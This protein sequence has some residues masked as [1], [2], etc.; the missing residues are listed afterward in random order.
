MRRYFP[1]ADRCAEVLLAAALLALAVPASAEDSA[2]DYLQQALENHEKVKAHY[3]YRYFSPERESFLMI[4]Q[5]VHPKHGVAATVVQPIDMAGM[6]TVD[7][8]KVMNVF[9]P[10]DQKVWVQASPRLTAFPIRQRMGLLNENYRVTFGEESSV[11]GREV[12]KIVISAKR[13]SVG[14]RLWYVD[15]KE[16][17]LLRSERVTEEGDV[18]PLLDVLLVFFNSSISKN[19]FKFDVDE[20]IEREKIPDPRPFK[21][22][23]DVSEELGFEPRIPRKLPYGFRTIKRQMIEVDDERSFVQIEVSD[24]M[25][26]ISIYQW[27][28]KVFEGANPS[29]IRSSAADIIGGVG[30]SAAGDAPP[31]VV[32]EILNQFVHASH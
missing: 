19:E 4:Q 32:K 11:A 27:S 28:Q 16:R 22:G 18:I 21:Y 9:S 31:S 23:K 13:S 8:G 29:G 30:F 5:F 6:R 25:G 14:D 20:D 3:F 24:G 26:R 17:V 1:R 2:K 12:R 7:D 10:L 15:E